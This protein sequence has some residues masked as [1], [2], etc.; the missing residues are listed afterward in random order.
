MGTL[1]D[2]VKINLFN[3]FDCCRRNQLQNTVSVRVR[4]YVGM[5]ALKSFFECKQ[6]SG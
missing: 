6:A 5:P 2:R 1:D 4:A 3:Q